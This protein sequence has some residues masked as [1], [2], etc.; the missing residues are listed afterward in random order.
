MKRVTFL[1]VALFLCGC[2]NEIVSQEIQQTQ[3]TPIQQMTVYYEGEKR[4]KE[5]FEPEQGKI[6]LGAFIKQDKI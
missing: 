2:T 6:L 5:I 3:Q 1:L 4:E